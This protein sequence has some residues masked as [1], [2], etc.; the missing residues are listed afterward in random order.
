MNKYDRKQK[1]LEK[2]FLSDCYL[3]EWIGITHN[4]NLDDRPYELKKL[5]G[6]FIELM[7]ISKPYSIKQQKSI[8]RQMKK[9]CRKIT[10][11]YNFIKIKNLLKNNT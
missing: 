7:N 2:Y 1:E 3:N 8:I 11:Y 6:Q 5:Q 4:R 10:Y 9:I